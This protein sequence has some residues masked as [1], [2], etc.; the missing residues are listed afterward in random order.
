MV[1]SRWEMAHVRSR[2]G[3]DYITI[4]SS[5]AFRSVYGG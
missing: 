3:D 2:T 1:V 5:L 4:F